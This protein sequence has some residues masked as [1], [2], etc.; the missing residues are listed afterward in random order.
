MKIATLGPKGT[1]SETAAE[2]YAK[3]NNVTDVKLEYVT[4]NTGLYRLQRR[5]VDVGV[6]PFENAVDGLIGATLDMLIDYHDFIKVCDEVSV[7]IRHLLSA[8]H[9]VGISEVRVV[10]SHASA[11][12]QCAR[13]L[14]ELAPNAM[15]VPVGSTAEAARI[16]RMS[17]DPYV[18]AICS[19]NA[20]KNNGLTV[21]DEDIQDYK[22]NATKFVVCALTDSPRTGD[23]RTIVAIRPGQDKPGLL[24]SILGELA[25]NDVN[26][27]YIQSRPYKVRPKEYIFAFE[28]EGHKIDVNVEAALHG[29]D[30]LMKETNGWKKILGSYP[31]REIGI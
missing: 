24:Y 23:D 1:Y 17:D 7:P 28:I 10:Y 15:L 3:R 16:V 6:F 8:R 20:V 5:E 13:R 2:L 29:L 26:L 27:T 31:R 14:E 30:R 19:E 12:N 22:T 21:L 18:A 11:L 9:S 4:V 25:H